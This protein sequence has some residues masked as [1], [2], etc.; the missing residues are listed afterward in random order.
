MKLSISIKFICNRNLVTTSI[1]PATTVLDF[2]RKDLHLTG[3]KEVCRE[4]DCGACTI[5]IGEI[6]DGELK[7]QT[8]NSC[9]LPIGKINGKH[10]VTIEG[11]NGKELNPIQNLI[12]DEGGT[13]CGFCT[14]GFIMSMTGYFLNAVKFNIE[15]LT[16]SLDGNICRCTGYSSIIRAAHDT[17]DSLKKENNKNNLEFLVEKKILPEYFLQIPDR[18]KNLETEIENFEE[19]KVNSPV[20]IS[21]GTD[22]FVQKPDEILDAPVYFVLKNKQNKIIWDE[23]NVCFI[24]A[25]ATIS[26]IKDSMLLKKFF[27]DIDKFFRLFGSLQIRNSATIGGNIVNASPIGDSTIF[28]LALNSKLHLKNNNS[29]R[30]VMLKDFYKGYKNLDLKDDERLEYLSFNLP[31]EEFFYSFEKV[32]KRTILDIAS[33]NSAIFLTMDGKLIKDIYISAGGVSP[34]PM[35]LEKTTAFLNGKEITEENILAASSIAQSEVSPID[36]VRGSA[37]YKKLLLRQILFS[38]FLKMF[39]E[40]VNVE[41]LV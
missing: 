23:D 4:G 3:T 2:I 41:E 33:V 18:L 20:I 32:S 24:H 19:E 6:I 8:I 36:D 27:P 1:H 38:H 35:L 7:Y 12:V 9:L 13:Q 14:P 11:L 40:K 39:P 21:G 29:S 34:V 5:L 30:E 16:A 28:F 26:D 17:I 15:S 31:K 22:L 10:I 25:S 37:E